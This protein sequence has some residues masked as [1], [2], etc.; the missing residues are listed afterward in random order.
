VTPRFEIGRTA[1]LLGTMLALTT[2]SAA[3][4]PAASR[5]KRISVRGNHIQDGRRP[6]SGAIEI[7]EDC[8]AVDVRDHTVQRQTQ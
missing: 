3:E 2:P 8:E 1:A 6:I 4:R 7:T 5:I